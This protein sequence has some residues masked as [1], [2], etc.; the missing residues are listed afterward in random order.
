MQNEHNF[1]EKLFINLFA[2]VDINSNLDIQEVERVIKD[3]GCLTVNT[4]A[5][6]KLTSHLKRMERPR[7]TLR[8]FIYL[9]I[10]TL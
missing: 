4:K 9:I 2:Y 8:L 5:D 6:K 10:S 1:V 7:K 3:G